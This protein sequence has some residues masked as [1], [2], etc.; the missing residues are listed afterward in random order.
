MRA[1]QILLY[2]LTGFVSFWLLLALKIALNLHFLVLLVEQVLSVSNLIIWSTKPI[3]VPS[4]QFLS[5]SR[6]RALFNFW[7][8]SPP[9]SAATLSAA[10]ASQSPSCTSFGSKEPGCS[11]SRATSF[12]PSIPHSKQHILGTSRATSWS[13]LSE[14]WP[15]LQGQVRAAWFDPRIWTALEYWI[16]SP[17]FCIGT[18][19]TLTPGST[20]INSGFLFTIS[21]D[22]SNIFLLT[23]LTNIIFSPTSSHTSVTN[24]QKTMSIERPKTGSVRELDWAD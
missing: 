18:T 9:V 16:Q 14:P 19:Q 11:H 20:F 1:P 10:T 15:G 12:C 7:D 23:L 4:Y 2:C 6:P 13:H 22:H 21:S 8:G 24:E 17:I 5:A 3:S